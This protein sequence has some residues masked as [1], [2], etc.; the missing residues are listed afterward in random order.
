[1][2][3]D[4]DALHRLCEESALSGANL[5]LAFNRCQ[6]RRTSNAVLPEESLLRERILQRSVGPK[7]RLNSSLEQKSH[8]A[9]EHHHPKYFPKL[10][11]FGRP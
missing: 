7:T 3:I 1:M 2:G 11:L 5:K 10:S 8:P 6:T 4:E 9:D